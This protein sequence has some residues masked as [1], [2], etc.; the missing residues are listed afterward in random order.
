MLSSLS[1]ELWGVLISCTEEQWFKIASNSPPLLWK[2]ISW[3]SFSCTA[4]K[5]WRA[6]DVSAVMAA[7][8]FCTVSAAFLPSLKKR[9]SCHQNRRSLQQPRSHLEQRVREPCLESDCCKLLHRWPCQGKSQLDGDPTGAG[10]CWQLPA[11]QCLSKKGEDEWFRGGVASDSCGVWCQL[12]FKQQHVFQQS[13]LEASPCVPY[14]GVWMRDPQKPV[15]VPRLAWEKCHSH[16]INT[17]GCF[18]NFL[19]RNGK[20]FWSQQNWAWY[21]GTSDRLPHRHAK[22][23]EKEF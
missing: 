16:R 6:E 11:A 21:T 12:V 22:Y 23:V 20:V 4:Q 15:C 9:E 17:D 18:C 1:A 10:G 13:Q 19:E 2:G 7:G 8:Y 14:E 5:G 3:S